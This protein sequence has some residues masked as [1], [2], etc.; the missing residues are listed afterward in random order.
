[1]VGTVVAL[2]PS[3]TLTVR[4]AG[5]TVVP[6][7]TNVSDSRGVVRGR[8]LRVFGPVSRPYLCVRPRRPPTPAEGASLLGAEML[9]E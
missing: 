9:R 2:T 7:G 8:V 6:E 4:A 3:G 1:M 5:A